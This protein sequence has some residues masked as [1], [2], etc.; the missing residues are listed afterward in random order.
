MFSQRGSLLISEL[1]GIA[2]SVVLSAMVAAGARYLIPLAHDTYV[3]WVATSEV[4][5]MQAQLTSYST[6]AQ[7]W[8]I[9]AKDIYGA[10]QV[11]GVGAAGA[12][13]L[14]QVPNPAPAEID[15]AIK[16]NA[17]SLTGTY[18]FYA[19]RYN[20][21]T[22]EEE[23][24][25]YYTRRS[26]GTALCAAATPCTTANT[27]VLASWAANSCTA[28]SLLASQ[29]HRSI[30]SCHNFRPAKRF[31][32]YHYRLAFRLTCS[33]ATSSMRFSAI[34]RRPIG[35]SSNRR[36]TTILRSSSKLPPANPSR[37][38]TFLCHILHRRS[39]Q[40]P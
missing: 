37:Q 26:D 18:A 14:V 3:A 16:Q 38:R 1:I 34:L 30:R 9:P 7:T 28:G 5:D 6:P 39:V 22:K 10:A 4:G 19:F 31:L 15:V 13:G 12:T 25:A 23:K 11:S 40:W 17:G 20:S 36:Q 21:T 29:I 2:G 35:S 24:I 8:F 27:V 33:R 32:T